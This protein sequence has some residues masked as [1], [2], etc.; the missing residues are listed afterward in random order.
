ME[1]SQTISHGVRSNSIA[2]STA[3]HPHR[4]TSLSPSSDSAGG[5]DE[6]TFDHD[7]LY[8]PQAGPPA[9]GPVTWVRPVG[10]LKKIVKRRQVSS[11]RV[12][13]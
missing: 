13:R 11:R 5:D 9:L 7:D 12:T 1:T 10:I 8:T 4:S 6:S 2:L 3:C